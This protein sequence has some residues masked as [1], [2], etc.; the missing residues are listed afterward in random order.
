MRKYLVL[1]LVIVSLFFCSITAQAVNSYIYKGVNIETEAWEFD[2]GYGRENDIVRCHDSDYYL[3]ATTSGSN[4]DSDLKIESFTMSEQGDITTAFT[5]TWTVVTGTPTA[6]NPVIRWVVNNTYICAYREYNSVAGTR[7]VKAFTFNCTDAGD[8]DQVIIDT[9]VS[10]QYGVDMDNSGNIDLCNPITNIW[11][12]VYTEY[13]TVDGWMHSFYIN[14]DDAQ[15]SAI[16]ASVEFDATTGLL[17]NL[18][19]LEEGY[20]FINYIMTG[21]DINMQTYSIDN[22]GAIASVESWKPY[23]T[24]NFIGISNAVNI[25]GTSYYMF[26]IGGATPYERV[27]TFKINLAGDIVSSVVDRLDITTGTGDYA[28]ETSLIHVEDDVYFILGRGLQPTTFTVSDLGIIPATYLFQ[29]FYTRFAQSP[30]GRW[31]GTI[32]GANCKWYP[33]LIDIS[34]VDDNYNTLLISYGD[35]GYSD[36]HLWNFAIMYAEFDCPE[37][38]DC[39][40]TNL[41]MYEDIINATGTHES[42]YDPD[43]GW[44]VWANYTGNASGCPECNSTNLTMYE[45][46]NNCTGDH[47]STYNSTT[48]WSVWA[49]Y[50]GNSSGNSS[51]VDL[52]GFGDTEFTAILNFF[53][54]SLFFIAGYRSKKRSGG[55]FMLLS[56]FFLIALSLSISLIFAQALLVPFAVFVAIVGTR[57]GLFRPEKEKTQSEGT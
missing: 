40:S 32:G 8:I 5:E 50:T 49:N 9:V 54:F 33:G 14:P 27:F 11:V 39:N 28:Y 20:F 25:P 18:C 56:A 26:G 22:T 48:G 47:N 42:S 17:P 55:A 37:C 24:T 15:I 19:V 29:G 7:Y 35:S 51:V 31:T 36:G 52:G 34:A 1:M 23:G 4:A 57:K 38:P 45:N 41:S 44:D 12:I 21:D 30:W 53:C 3:L 43:T 16:N 13:S 2:T 46:I 10:T 6:I